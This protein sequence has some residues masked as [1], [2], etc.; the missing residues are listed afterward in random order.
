MTRP[1]L[2]G[3]VRPLKPARRAL[4]GRIALAEGGSAGYESSLERDWLMALDFDWRVNRLQE[5]P[6]TIHY[7]IEGRKRRYT[8]DVLAEY[9]DGHRQATVVYE[10]KPH[11]VLRQSW[12]D[13]RPRFKA[14]VADCRARGWRFRIV[15]ERHIRTPYLDNVK[16][17]RRYR[18]LPDQVM[19]HEALLFTLRALGDT[20]PQA[21]LAATWCDTERRMAALAELWRLVATFRIGADLHAPV[22]MA[23]PIWLPR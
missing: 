19:H 21:L 10:V 17:L 16:F 18:H 1:V 3:P 13:L 5:Q 4:T 14:A 6:Y 23:S 20:T 7:A 12:Q 22:T 2:S 15:T 9:D 8:P 11:E